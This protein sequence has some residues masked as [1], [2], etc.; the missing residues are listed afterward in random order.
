MKKLDF[1]KITFIIRKDRLIDG[2]APIYLQLFL[3]SQRVRIL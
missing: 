1:L 2:K 3:D